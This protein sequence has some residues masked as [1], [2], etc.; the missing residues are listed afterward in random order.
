M[1]HTK[2]ENTMNRFVVLAALLCATAVTAKAQDAAT[3][4]P[5][6]FKVELQNDQVRVLRYTLAPHE[7]TAIHEHTGPHLEI[8]LTNSKEETTVAGGR[9]TTSE[10]KA[11]HVEWEGTLGKHANENIGDTPVE[12]IVIELKGK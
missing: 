7:T 8:Q 6:H 2:Q 10:N 12:T 9:G 3:A 11:G 1:S 4:D 5:K